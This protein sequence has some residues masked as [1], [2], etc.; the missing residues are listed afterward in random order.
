MDCQ[1]LSNL[2]HLGQRA[3]MTVGS[4]SDFLYFKTIFFQTNML[5][6]KFESPILKKAYSRFFGWSIDSCLV[7]R[8]VFSG[9]FVDFF[10]Q[11]YSNL[12][13]SFPLYLFFVHLAHL[14]LGV[15]VLIKVYPFPK[16]N[17]QKK[18]KFH[19]TQSFNAY[20]L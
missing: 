15:L 16:T 10:F 18:I 19:S 20:I 2:P 12:V 3:S 17:K 7:L 8:G 4:K 5:R 14:V 11:F 6:L 1:I 9:F 13:M